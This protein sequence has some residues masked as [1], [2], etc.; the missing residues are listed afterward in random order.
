M[1]LTPGSGFEAP[2]NGPHDPVLISGPLPSWPSSLRDLGEELFLSLSS[3]CAGGPPEC[4]GQPENI[5]AVRR[6][7]ERPLLT[8]RGHLD[9]LPLGEHGLTAVLHDTASAGQRVVSQ[10]GM[11]VPASQGSG[12][13]CPRSPIMNGGLGAPIQEG[14]YAQALSREG[15]QVAHRPGQSSLKPKEE[16]LLPTAARDTRGQSNPGR[17]AHGV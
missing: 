8:L 9:G 7:A 15:G 14:G 3:Y 2:S 5:P 13:A 6:P 16:P 12:V 10:E 4:R 11:A 17:S 1:A